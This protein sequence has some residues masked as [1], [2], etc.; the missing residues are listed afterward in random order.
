MGMD[1]LSLHGGLIDY[2]RQL[3]TVR[4]PNGGIISIYRKDTRVCFAFYSSARA[5]QC[6]QHGCLGYLAYVVDM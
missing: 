1:W 3:V 6:L 2:E 5:R 4:D